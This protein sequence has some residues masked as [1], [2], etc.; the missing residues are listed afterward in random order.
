MESIE[1]KPKRTWH[2]GPARCTIEECRNI[3]ESKGGICLSTEYTNNKAKLQWRCSESH[4][5]EASLSD[6]KNNGHWCPRCSGRGRLTI[7]DCK[8]IAEKEGYTCLSEKYTNNKTKLVWQCPA[9][10]T[11]ETS[12]NCFQKGCRC[13]LCI[14]KTEAKV[15][16]IAQSIFPDT[17]GNFRPDWC[18]N[19]A[20]KCGLPFDIVIPSC[21]CIIEV[22]GPQHFEST[23]DWGSP[24]D[25]FVRD[26]IKAKLAFEHG[27]K[28]IR[29]LQGDVWKNLIDLQVQLIEIC[30]DPSRA[31]VF[32]TSPGNEA[33]YN[34]H[35]EALADITDTETRV[36]T[37][38]ETEEAEIDLKE[39]RLKIKAA[40]EALGESPSEEQK[41]KLAELESKLPRKTAEFIPKARA[42]HGY[43]F[44]YSQSEYVTSN[45][46]LTLS[47][48]HH[49]EMVI[50]P[51][52]H[53]LQKNGCPSCSHRKLLTIDECRELAET[54]GGKCL[55]ETYSSMKVKMDWECA[56]GHTWKALFRDI[57]HS[58]SWCPKCAGRKRLNIDDCREYA[59]ENGFECVSTVYKD[60]KSNLEW[61][62]AEGHVFSACFNNVKGNGSRCP[63]CY[64]IRRG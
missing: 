29:I 18:F 22:D 63:I 59:I 8:D 21:Y 23:R 5:W 11:Y 35:K 38:E 46:Q 28:M 26:I 58:K 51:D 27:Y 55:S 45:D 31:P 13:P 15:L 14:N 9:G 50:R 33:V 1:T 49:G 62:C 19:P 30:H 40:F 16:A 44:D 24:D 53:I 42:V 57:K 36:Y 39:L 47:C 32:V 20:T 54:R 2:G 52:N 56:K 10:H 61:Q 41:A 64:K 43:H 25:I 6:I 17:K 60:M 48:K 3:A 12:Y 37:W 4:E 7:K 34:K